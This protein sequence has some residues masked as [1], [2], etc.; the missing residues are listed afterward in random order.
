MFL[1]FFF[2]MREREG[3]REGEGEVYYKLG[4]RE[5]LQAY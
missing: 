1:V 2:L 5:R 3:E 4:E